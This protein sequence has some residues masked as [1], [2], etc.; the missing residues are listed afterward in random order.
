MVTKGISNI[1]GLSNVANNDNYWIRYYSQESK[2]FIT[3]RTKYVK[4]TSFRRSP[5]GLHWLETKAT[6]TIEDREVFI[7][8]V[9]YNK[10]NYTC[11]S[12][13]RVN[14]DRKLQRIIGRP[15]FKTLKQIIRRNLLTNCPVNIADVISADDIFGPNEGSLCGETV[16]TRPQ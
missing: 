3:T 15:S 11:C 2:Y 7:N 8:T 6:K 5:L 14:L 13:L 12:Y 16:R 10:S 4:E 9:E 1:L